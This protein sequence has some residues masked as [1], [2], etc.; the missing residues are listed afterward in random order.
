MP[1]APVD[2][3]FSGFI[4]YLIQEGLLTESEAKIHNQEAQTKNLP[5]IKLPGCKQS[6]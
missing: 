1:T 2:F 5:V 4:K 6:C 3:Q